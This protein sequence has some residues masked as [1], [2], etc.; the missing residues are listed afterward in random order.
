VP[1]P[2][3]KLNPTMPNTTL[4]LIRH[5]ETS[6]N[7]ER[8]FQGHTDVPLNATGRGQAK[9]LAERLKED[10]LDDAFTAIYSSDL[11]RARETAAAAAQACGLTLQIHSGL[12]ERHYGVLS[13]LTP[14]EMA[15][16]HPEAYAQWQVRNPDYV[17]PE[18]ESLRGFN[19][20][21]MDTLTEIAEAHPGQQVLVVAHGGVLDCA[22]RAATG[23]PLSAR[24][25]HSLHNAS[26]NR[27]RFRGGR[28]HVEQWGDIAHL[29]AE[30]FDEI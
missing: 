5:G 20:R 26:I 8:R 19:A 7:A 10:H 11:G 27:V 14:E 30:A 22:Y 24:R 21:V 9:R 16:R 3:F 25:E 2:Y 29:E 13:A 28:Y 15:V 1:P 4:W 23:Q 12:R 18:G 17:L 6:W